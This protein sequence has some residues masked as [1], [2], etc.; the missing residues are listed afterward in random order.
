MKK[1]FVLRSCT[2][3]H[4]STLLYHLA[5]GKMMPLANHPNRQLT[6]FFYLQAGRAKNWRAVCD[7]GR[8]AAMAVGCGFKFFMTFLVRFWSSKNEQESGTTRLVQA[9]PYSS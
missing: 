5:C 7:H 3:P 2:L 4:F 6:I 1:A 9:G 8:R